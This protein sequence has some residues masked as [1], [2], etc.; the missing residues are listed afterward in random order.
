MCQQ[1]YDL[2]ILHYPPY[3]FVCLLPTGSEERRVL[4][5][6]NFPFAILHSCMKTIA[7]GHHEIIV[8]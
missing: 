6:E 1:D 7:E 8:D 3:L 5:V 2:Y 4:G